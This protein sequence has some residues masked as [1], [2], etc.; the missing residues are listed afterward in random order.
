MAVLNEPSDYELFS[1]LKTTLSGD[2][3]AIFI[4]IETIDEMKQHTLEIIKENLLQEKGYLFFAYPKK[5]N[6]RYDTFIH[7]DEI[8]PALGTDDD[9]YVMN[10]DLKFSRMV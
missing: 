1:G 7:R 6:K 8:F 3:D 2:H 9:G 10:S 4:F 5:G